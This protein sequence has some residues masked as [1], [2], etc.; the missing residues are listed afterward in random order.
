MSATLAVRS[1]RPAVLDDVPLRVDRDEVLRFQ[2]YKKDVDV[3]DA[4]V[5]ALFEEALGLGESLIE[6]RVV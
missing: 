5:L 6:P 1:P 4:T 3:P 2:G